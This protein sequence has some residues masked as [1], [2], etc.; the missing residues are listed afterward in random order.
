MGRQH[1]RYFQHNLRHFGESKIGSLLKERLKETMIKETSQMRLFK[2]NL[3][4]NKDVENM[5]HR[6]TEAMNWN[7]PHN[8]FVIVIQIKDVQSSIP[9]HR[10]AVTC[11]GKKMY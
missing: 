2:V 9:W 8:M 10:E 7:C 6:S 5:Y 11:A 3:Q 4:D 1:A